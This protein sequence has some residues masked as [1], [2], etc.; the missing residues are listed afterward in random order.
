MNSM[1]TAVLERRREIG[2]MKAIGAKNF[3]ILSFFTIES[4]LLGLIGGA[5]GIAF[6]IAFSKVVEYFAYFYL[7]TYLIKVSFPPYLIAGAL[8]F[9]FFIGCV[10]GFAP[11][12][13]AARMNP[14]DALRQT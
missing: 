12:M 9:S 10:S 7:G 4:G 11:A 8:A 3:D 6:G 14:V 5:I 13:Q 2:I 1:Y